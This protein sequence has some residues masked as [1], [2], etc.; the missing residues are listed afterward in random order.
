MAT[1]THRDESSAGPQ[2]PAATSLEVLLH[3]DGSWVPG[4]GRETL[5]IVNPASARVIGSVA[6]ATVADLERA[7]EAAARGFATWRQVPPFDRAQL[8]RRAGEK[9]SAIQPGLMVPKLA[10]PKPTS[11]RKQISMAK[12]CA[13]PDRSVPR[14]QTKT[15]AA[16]NHRRGQRS[17]R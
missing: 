1:V 14:L 6:K 9:R 2:S 8:L 4:A 13:W 17:P 12:P 3:V 10:S 15:P 5:P 16:I 11:T 7:V